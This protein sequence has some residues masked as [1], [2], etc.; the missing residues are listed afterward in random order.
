ML[1][2]VFKKIKKKKI[3]TVTNYNEKNNFVILY[4][5]MIFETKNIA[6]TL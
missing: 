5:Y 4:I 2:K 3:V 1:Y 6:I